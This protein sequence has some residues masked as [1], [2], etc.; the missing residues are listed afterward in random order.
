MTFLPWQHSLSLSGGVKNRRLKKSGKLTSKLI[1]ELLED[2]TVPALV[3]WTGAGGDFDWNNAANWGGTLPGAADDVV[4]DQAGI[5]INHSAGSDDS[6]NSLVTQSS[7]AVS[8]GSLLVA[9][10]STIYGS[11]TLSATYGGSGNTTVFGTIQSTGGT[12]RGVGGQGSLVGLSGGT[13]SGLSLQE[14]FDLSNPQNQTITWSGGLGLSS[15]SWFTN[16]GTLTLT[17]DSG[18]SSNPG[19]LFHNTVTGRLIK[20][21]GST[22]QELYYGSPFQVDTINDG[23]IRVDVGTIGLGYGIGLFE[24]HGSIVAH[25]AAGQ[26]KTTVWLL[27]TMSSNGTIDA[28]RVRFHG[29]SNSEIATITGSFKAD[30]T[31]VNN[32]NVR[33]SGTVLGL[34]DVIIGTWGPGPFDLTGA[35]F[36]PG[37]TTLPSLRLGGTLITSED[38]TVTGTLSLAGTLRGVGGQGSL[39]GL[40]GGTISGLSLQEGFDLT[41]PQNQTITWSGGLGLSSGSWF[42]NGGTLTLT[43]DGGISSNPGALFHN[44]VTG[45]LIKAGGST[46]QELY[47]GSPFQVDTINDGLIRVDVGTIGLGYG[48][49]LFENHG[50]IVAHAAA[51]QPKTTVWLLETMS[52]NGTIDADRVRFHGNS[53]SEIATI[54]GSFK[55]DVTEVNNV[56]VRMSGT[57][58]GL[59]DVIIGTWGPGPFDL[60][61][62]TFAPGTTTLPSLRLGGT[63]ITS[64]DLTVTGTLSLAGT[65][66]GV[67][68]QGSLVGLSG[69]TIS[70]LSLQEGFDLTNPQNQTITWSGGLGLSSGSWFTNGGT[71]TLTDDGGISSNPGALF[72]NTVTGRLIKAGG[73]TSQELYYGS[74]FQVD[75]INDGLIRVDVGTIGLGYGIGLFENH[76]SIVAHA[77]AGQPK[78]TVWLLETMSSNGTIDADRVR[79]HGNSNS[80]IATIT[81]SFKA[82]VTEVNNVNVRMSGTVLGLGDVIIGT[83]GP[84]PFDLTGA[85]FAPGTTTL[86]SLRLGGTLI[87]SEDLTVTGTLSL[88]GTLRGVGGQ[89]SLVGLSGGTISGLSLQ[90]GFDLTNPQNQTITWSGGLGLSSGSWFTNGGTLTLT[91]DGGISSNP[92]ALFHNTVT[93]RLIKAG[94]STSQE[95]YYGSPFQVDTINDG[96]IR[97]DVGTIGLGYGIG[98][99][100]NHGSIVAHAAAGQPK[101]TVWLLETMS[102]NG[103]IDADRV[104]FHGNSNS[105]I[106]TIT[107]SFKADVTEVNN[108]NVRMSGTVLGLGDVIIG[109]WGPGPFD[110]TGATF[111]SGTT[112]LPSLTINGGTL[113]TGAD[114]S[115]NGPFNWNGGTLAGV[116]GTGSLTVI[117]DMTL[118]GNYNVSDFNLKN[119]GHAIWSGGTVQFYGEGSF[120]NLAGATFDDQIDGSFGSVDNNCPEFYNQGLF[121]K[122]GGNGPTNLH[123]MLINSGTVQIDHGQLVL[124]CGYAQTSPSD[125]LPPGIVLPPGVP[126]PGLYVPGPIEVTPSP[127]P[128]PV[129]SSFTQTVSGVL[130]EQIGGTIAGTQY[131]Q[132][133][134]NGDVALNGIFQVQVLSPYVPTLGQQFLVI[135]NRGNNPIDGTF[136]WLP[137]GAMI[138]AGAYGFTISYVGGTGNDFVL[139]YSSL[140]QV[141]LSGHVFDD[142][143]NDGVF[144]GSDVG[145]TGVTLTLV[146]PS[147]VVFS[148]A[149]TDSNGRY[150]FT[151]TFPADTYRIVENQ[152]A[153][154][155][156]G[157]EM[158]GSLGGTTNNNQDNNSITNIVLGA[159]DI[160]MDYDFAELRPS[161]IQ[162]LVWRDSDNDGEVDFGELAIDGVTITLTGTD[163]RGQTVNAGLSTDAQGIVE[164]INLRPGNY[165]LIETQPAGYNDGKDTLGTVNGLLTGNVTVNDQFSQIVL[166]DA[167]SDAVNYNFGEIPAENSGVHA[168]QT[169]SI[170]FWQNKNGQNLIK[171]LNGGAA[172]TQLSNWLAATFPNMYGASAGISNLTGKTNQ[173]VANLYVSLFKRNGQTSLGGPPKLDAQVLATALAVYVTKQSL[174]GTV[175]AAYGFEVS[176]DGVGAATFN[177]GNKGAAL[178]VSNN[179]TMSVLDILLSTNARTVN[180]V[181][182]DVDGSGS[183]SDTERSLRTQANDLFASINELGGI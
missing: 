74:P 144:N 117:S 24:N 80:E 155:L 92:G 22:S 33:M 23:L 26:P 150:T 160:G 69:G 140:A 36:A 49:G 143:N 87:T 8:G 32:V 164:F 166:A 157:K 53:N 103:T 21:G 112:T 67:G 6:I 127:T 173:Q 88:A 39:V 9:S 169:A 58:L 44:T 95:L 122:S 56:N 70:G 40:S 12:L 82:D 176:A 91:D 78:T 153:G 175:A 108:V 179:T 13:I 27:E 77:A 116:G 17:D 128:P 183:I 146:N 129:F 135:D 110:L 31:E 130:I 124:G 178:G 147:D 172:A 177:V 158:A 106:A 41:N 14:G 182:Y 93:G 3:S 11:L 121:L 125:P 72:H 151:G 73:S 51:G 98:L 165:T 152:P 123:M 61:G 55:A 109:T 126:D 118:Y 63:L 141:Y 19:A 1:V 7:V 66:R 136:N 120:T 34:G 16:G 137:E 94:G 115:V 149:I 81:G 132:L 2:R 131:G 97:V 102:S 45:R 64:E 142:L 114:L 71:L 50:S 29:N 86:P 85:T 59:G 139:T 20:A 107:G 60:T 161:R 105:E 54:T 15:G 171:S 65:L 181:L 57:V 168:G 48:I 89:G 180:G 68:G 38:L 83:W 174:A 90:E 37:T 138:W 170:G 28:D 75:T 4:I 119:A 43:D 154:F 134:V 159:S 96:L 145:I 42:T 30:V 46:S 148:T 62:A 167:G 79:F 104:R 10:T 133:V 111:A 113:I 84:G 99:F 162:S 18:I 47:Y 163:D 156:D 52:S 101:T 5:T 100:E 76:G 25:A 35:T